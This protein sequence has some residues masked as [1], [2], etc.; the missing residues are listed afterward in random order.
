M[1]PPRVLVTRAL[2]DAPP[3]ARA[4]IDGGLQPVLVPMLERRFCPEAVADVARAH[5]KVDV[6]FV[7][8]P[9]AAEALAIGAP[10]AWRDATWAAVGPTTE[11]RLRMLGYAV[12]VV[13]AK[14]TALDLVAA[15]GDL[16]GQVVAW[17]RGDL[18]SESTGAGLLGSGATV[19]DV[20]AY[21]NVAPHGIVARLAGALP[22][23]ATT[24]MSGSAAERLVAALDPERVAEIGKVVCIGP[25]TA[26]VARKLGLPVDAVA[27]P[28][29]MPGVVEA[30]RRL[31]FR[32]PS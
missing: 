24:L 29:T 32:P 25:S 27:S 5:P 11:R 30:T 21:E 26:E 6:V 19:V 3:L 16:S 17:P 2:P 12:A 1:T 13:P 31:L 14:A 20:V 18:A 22:V 15:L 10:S 7:T 8:S 9:A 28:H 4:L 23:A